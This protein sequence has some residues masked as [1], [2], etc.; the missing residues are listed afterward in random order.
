MKRGRIKVAEGYKE[1]IVAEAQGSVARFN[2]IAEQY[3]LSPEITR[4]RLYLE[5]MSRLLPNLKLTLIDE[6]AGIVNLKNL[7][8]PVMQMP[9]QQQ[10]GVQQ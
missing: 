5:T 1:A 8:G 7:E 3:R 2:A 6:S 10:Q 4:S 9:Q